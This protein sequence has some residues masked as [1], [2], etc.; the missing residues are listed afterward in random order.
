MVPHHVLDQEGHTVE[1]PTME[2]LK[3][4]MGDALESHGNAMAAKV[5]RWLLG[6][7]IGIVAAAVMLYARM[8]N[9]VTNM[10]KEGGRTAAERAH[11][12]AELRSVIRKVD[13]LTYVI[14]TQTALLE[15]IERR[16]R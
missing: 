7:G 10:E 12:T 6:G 5:L 8:D 13:S 3:S 15:R 2:D 4:C 9:R 1:L 16:L 11:D 14:G